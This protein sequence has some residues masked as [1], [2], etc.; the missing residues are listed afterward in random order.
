MERN[1][2]SWLAAVLVF[3]T[4]GLGWNRSTPAALCGKCRDLMFIE[5]E[6]KCSVCG[7]PTASGALQL[8]PKCSAK[9]HQCEHCLA[10]T[11][12]KDETAA[13]SKPAEPA[14][15]RPHR[16]AA[17]DANDQSPPAWNPPANSGNPARPDEKPAARSAGPETMLLPPVAEN[18]DKPAAPGLLPESKPPAALPL[19]PTPAAARKPINPA[20]A[21]TYTSEKWRFQMQITSPGTKSEGRWGWLTYDGQKLPRGEV[22]DYYNTPWGPIFWVDVPTTAWG[23]H[24]W[25]PVPLAQNRRQGRA[26]ASPVSVPASPSVAAARAASPG[27]SAAAAAA[28]PRLQTLEINKSHNGQLARVRVGNVLVIRLPGDPASGYQW[29]SA[30][31]NSSAVRLTVRPQYSPPAAGAAVSGTY[32]FTFQAVQPGTGSIRLYYVRPSDPSRPRDTFAVGVN[33]SPATVTARPVAN[34]R[35]AGE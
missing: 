9:R 34:S 17:A 2:F 30:T 8:C 19:D 23:V 32:T 35:Q 25:M 20:R 22:N 12:G 13:E 24:G 5:S 18:S 7:G 10:A 6:G 11:T 28:K 3:A 33:V 31:T 26:L 29:Q 4:A 21:G 14:A 16:D 15:D 1:L 27:P